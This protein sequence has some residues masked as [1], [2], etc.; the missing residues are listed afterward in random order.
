[1]GDFKDRKRLLSSVNR[2]LNKTIYNHSIAT[3]IPPL[4]DCWKGVTI[5]GLSNI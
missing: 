3:R 5:H 4:S 1:M 2:D